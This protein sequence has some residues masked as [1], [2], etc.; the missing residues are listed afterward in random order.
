MTGKRRGKAG[1]RPSLLHRCAVLLLLIPVFLAL[2]LAAGV[3]LDRVTWKTDS[4]L[5]PR[6]YIALVEQASETWGVPTSVIY[7]VIRTESSFREDAVSPANA[8]G[9]MQLTDDTYEWLY[10]LRGKQADLDTIM[11]PSYNIDAGCSLLA[12]LYE[13]Y[14]VWETVYA[15]YNAGYNRVNR[16]LEDPA[17][18]EDGRLVHIPIA[19]TENYVRIVGE[20]EEMYRTL[21]ETDEP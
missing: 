9:L 2:A 5:Y 14:G 18:S 11:I 8:K 10:F 4:I 21:Y 3:L 19:E 15:A 12:W 20:T 16:W 6:R 1:I 17:I 7:A 13:R